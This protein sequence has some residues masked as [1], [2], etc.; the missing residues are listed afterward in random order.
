MWSECSCEMRM[1]STRS[2][3][4]PK[5]ASRRSVSLRLKPASTSSRVL[6][7]STSVQLPELPEPRLITRT[8]MVCPR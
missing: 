1:A 2:V 6:E 5:A 4:A 8:A 7:V 3:E